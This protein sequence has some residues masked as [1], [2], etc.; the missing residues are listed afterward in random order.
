MVA[1][2][3]SGILKDKIALPVMQQVTNA[4]TPLDTYFT[5]RS[6]TV[7]YPLLRNYLWKI[8]LPTWGASLQNIVSTAWSSFTSGGLEKVL[9]QAK[10]AAVSKATDFVVGK[11]TG[12]SNNVLPMG[13]TPRVISATVPFPSYNME[14]IT[15]QGWKYQYPSEESINNLV[16]EWYADE[17][18][19]ALAYYYTWFNMIKNRDGTYNYPNLYERDIPITLYRT[20][21][22]PV[23]EFVAKSVFPVSIDQLSLSDG[24]SGSQIVKSFKVTMNL[25]ELGLVSINKPKQLLN[26]LGTTM[27][28]A[29]QNRIL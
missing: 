21:G 23:I 25:N 20:D 4:L 15:K 11:V 26:A 3:V 28:S 16:M 12:N 13:F 29:I 2:N 14:S 1:I 22:S 9:N 8:T 5:V 17:N 10:N 18:G 27:Y 7:E 24:K 19:F 6:H